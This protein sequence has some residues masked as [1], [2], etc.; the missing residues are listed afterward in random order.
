MFPNDID[1]TTT[2]T[3]KHFD[4]KLNILEALCRF[5]NV[6]VLDL[7]VKHGG[8]L[9]QMPNFD[10]NPIL[11]CCRYKSWKAVKYLLDHSSN[12]KIPVNLQDTNNVYPLW[13][14]AA[15]DQVDI[16]KSMLELK[17]DLKCVNKLGNTIFH[18]ISLRLRDIHD[19]GSS[20]VL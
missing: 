12:N 10:N 8:D 14:A 15:D 4:G 17:A 5:D 13:Y 9:S 1:F 11:Y 3:S 20:S 19:T 7:L 6:D 18:D 2:F 16:V